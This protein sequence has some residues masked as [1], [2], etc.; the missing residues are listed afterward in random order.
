MSDIEIK[1]E[2]EKLSWY[3]EIDVCQGVRTKSVNRF[4]ISWELIESG[5]M[6][7]DLNGRRVLDIGTRDGKYAFAAERSGAAVTAIDSDQSQGALLLK[8]YFGSKVEFRQQSLYELKDETFDVV[9]FFGVL[10][11]LRYP[12]LGLATIAKLIPQGGLLYI[13][14]GMMDAHEN[15]PMLY[16]PVRTSPYEITSC[17]FFNLNGLT[18]TLWSFGFTVTS[19]A[20]HPRET[21]G[22]VKRMWIE[23]RK[24]H[25]VTADLKAYWNS[26][27]HSHTG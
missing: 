6:R 4:P 27:H 23:A 7:M 9:F 12:M 10:Y 5:M 26:T 24:T 19:H 25:E 3:H 15:M 8:D 18:E 13:E 11:H 22:F 17:T 2:V 14:S 1:A 16:C 21:A 20:K